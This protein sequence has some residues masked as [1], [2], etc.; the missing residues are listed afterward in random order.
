L[1]ALLLL[2][3][4]PAPPSL[5]A[6]SSCFTWWSWSLIAVAWFL[7]WY[8]VKNCSWCSWDKMD[9]EMVLVSLWGA[10]ANAGYVFI[11]SYCCEDSTWYACGDCAA[12]RWSNWFPLPLEAS[13]SCWCLSPSV[14]ILYCQLAVLLAK[15]HIGLSMSS[16]IHLNQFLWA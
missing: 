7:W 13:C 2:L 4:S 3:G 5:L 15:D 6:C 11:Y 1:A 16:M 9:G 8:F 14:I 10:A 12:Y